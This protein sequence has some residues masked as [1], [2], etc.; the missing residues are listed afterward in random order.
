M[1][2]LLDIFILFALV[3]GILWC[4]RRAL[5]RTLLGIFT[6]FL[7][8]LFSAL[9]YGPIITWFGTVSGNASSG[10]SAGSFVFGGLLI[11]FD[12]VLEVTIHRNYP[13]LRLRALKSWDH[14]LGAIVGVVWSAFVI[15][16]VIVVLN[17]ASVSFGGDAPLIPQL[18]A[19]S[20]LVPGFREFFKLPLLGIRP[21]FPQ[22]LPEILA[23]FAR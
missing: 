1:G 15:T 14:I 3:G 22:G 5:V 18:V 7:A 19:T 6:L 9:L 2:L 20:G 17:F 11:A 21:L 13:D 10:R 12:I 16:L 8:T 4:M 23:V